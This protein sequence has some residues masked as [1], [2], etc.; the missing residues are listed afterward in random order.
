MLVYL[1][2]VLDCGQRMGSVMGTTLGMKYLWSSCPGS[3][4]DGASSHGGTGL[5]CQEGYDVQLGTYEIVFHRGS[6]SQTYF[7]DGVSRTIMQVH[8]YE[9]AELT[10][11]TNTVQAE[12]TQAS[13]DDGEASGQAL[14]GAISFA[15][16]TRLGYAATGMGLSFCLQYCHGR[17]QASSLFK[18]NAAI[19]TTCPE[20]QH[21]RGNEKYGRECSM[22]YIVSVYGIVTA[23]CA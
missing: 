11:S 15:T 17:A 2:E 20:S 23:Q 10:L 3:S 7:Q 12:A 19:Y 1:P 6:W 18:Y 8:N 14:Q 4:L 16:M 22:P 13:S 9:I 5:A 21:C